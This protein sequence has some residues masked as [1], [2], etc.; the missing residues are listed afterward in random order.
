MTA[1][2]VALAKSSTTSRLH[3]LNLN[4]LVALSALLGECNVTRAAKR[5]GVTQSAMSQT[6]AR[7]RE[8]F[9]DVLLV[10]TGRG[11]VRTQ[12]AEAML[13]PLSDALL[14]VER[15]VQLGMGFDPAVSSRVFRV[16]MS[17]LHAALLLPGLVATIEAR[18]P[19]LRIEAEAMSIH[20][21]ADEITSGDVDLAVGFLLGAPLGLS[22]E[23]L[24]TD[25]F[26]CLVRR[27]HPLARKKRV[28]LA[29][30]AKQRHLTCTPLGAIPKPFSGSTF[31]FGARGGMQ[32]SSPYLLASPSVVRST[33]LVATV[34]RRVLDAAIDLSGLV[35][36]EAPVELPPVVHSMW[37]H[38][39]YERDPGHLWLRAEVRALCQPRG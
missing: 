25:D 23:A 36:V 14:A 1:T 31:G 10:R 22:T 11:L 2:R 19:E 17:D 9:D 24:E 29:T 13:G 8:L 7:M 15:A 6:L 20:G 12:R 27:G 38:P 28:D 16:A 3:A 30:Y 18:A 37:W 34:P 39:R 21:L 5:V 4:A 32:V 33:G 26:V 35:V